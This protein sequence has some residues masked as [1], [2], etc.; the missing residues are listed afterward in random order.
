MN[1]RMGHTNTNSSAQGAV[2]VYDSARFSGFF[3]DTLA[4]GRIQA[5]SASLSHA[6]NLDS[7]REP[8]AGL[9]RKG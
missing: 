1:A 5:L 6:A 8:L 7:L 3:L 9:P 4:E 2:S